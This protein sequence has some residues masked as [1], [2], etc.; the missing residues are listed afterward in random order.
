MLPTPA[1][2]PRH[3]GLRYNASVTRRRTLSVLFSR[4]RATNLSLLLLATFAVFSFLLNI[5]YYFSLSLAHTPPSSILS[6][7]ARQKGLED[8]VHLIIVPGH[9][10]WKGNN[11]EQ[12]M[13]E[14]EWILEPYQRGV[15]GVSAFYNH[16]VRG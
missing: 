5:R 15:G 6:T 3:S 13:D 2:V 9:A 4:S 14:N 12:I 1:T 11:A 7:F 8:L 10:I 16:I